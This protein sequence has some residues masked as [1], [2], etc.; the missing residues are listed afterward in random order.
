[1]RMQKEDSHFG[2]DRP[3][4]NGDVLYVWRNGPVS[5][6]ESQLPDGSF[7]TMKCVQALPETM[8]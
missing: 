2:T 1:M 4:E 6:K 8:C 7:C 3:Q 5:L